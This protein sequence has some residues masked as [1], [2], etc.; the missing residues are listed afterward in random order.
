MDQSKMEEIME[1]LRAIEHKRE[2][3]KAESMAIQ[4]RIE[5]EMKATQYNI[6]AHHEEMMAKMDAW[7]GV[8]PTCLEEEEEPAPEEP[9]A[10]AETEEVPEGVTDEEA[11]SH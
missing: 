5:A 11:I 7:R 4:L 9:K 8:T 10:V 1:F 2:A 6:K 3:D